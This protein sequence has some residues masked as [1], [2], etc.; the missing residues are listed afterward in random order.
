[1]PCWKN[2]GESTQSCKYTACP[3]REKL[4]II[5]AKPSFKIFNEDMVGAENK[6]VNLKLNK[7]F[8]IGQTIL[9]LFKLVMYDLHYNFMQKRYGEK[10]ILLFTIIQPDV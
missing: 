9:D 3:H 8:Y 1:M 6:I 4:K 7:R 5:C 10:I 2:D